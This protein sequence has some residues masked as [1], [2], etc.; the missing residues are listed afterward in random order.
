[1]KKILFAIISLMLSFSGV[2]AY[3]PPTMGWS[4]WNTYGFQISEQLIMSQTSAMVDKGLKDVGYKYINIDDGFFGGRDADGNLLIHPTRFPNGMKKVVDFIHGKGLKAGIYSDAGRN[5]CASFWGGDKIGE[6]VGLYG[7]DQ[8]DIDLYFKEL[9]F[10]FIKVDFCGGAPEHNVDKLDLPE[11]E[12]YRAIHEA[13]VNTGRTDVRLNVCRWAFPGTWVHEVATSWRV[14]EDI[15]LGWNSVKGIIGQTLYLSAFATEGKFND[16]DMLEVGRGLTA[17]EDKTHFGMWCMLSS[18]LLIGC[19]M[20]KLGG[21]ALQ[22]LKNEE[23]I[24]LNQ[25]PLALQAYVVKRENG[26]YVLV[27]DV[28]ELNGS[29]RAVAFYNP[30]D[31]EL[32]MDV[33]FID[34]DLGGSVKV[35]D[36]FEKEDIG[37]FEGGYDVKVPAH[38]TRI[39]KLEAEKRYE[40]RV[41]EAE[42]AW[43]DAYQELVNNQTAE[44]GI[45]EETD[46]CS[47]GA[48]A[49]WLGRSK[50]NSLEWRNVYSK[51]GGEYNI[52]IVYITGETRKVNVVVNGE[53][54]Q[55]LSLNSGGWNSPKTT[56]LTVNLQKGFNSIK[57]Y[58][59]SA[60]MP[61]IDCMVLDKVGVFDVY[62]ERIDVLCN[63]VRKLCKSN[64]IPQ[65]MK[66]SLQEAVEDAKNVE[67]TKDA[68]N[69]AISQLDKMYGDACETESVYSKY[70]AIMEVVKSNA[71]VT[72]ACDAL[73][74]C[75]ME[76][77]A[78]EKDMEASETKNEA[79]RV[80]NSFTVAV[81]GYLKS[82]EMQPQEGKNWDMTLLISN[83]SF[84]TDTKGWV[85]APVFGHSVAEHYNK[86]FNTYQT[87]TGLKN[88]L[89]TVQ[90]NAL[91]RIGENDG[92]R[93]YNAGTE[94]I[95]AKFFANDKNKPIVS[96]YTYPYEGETDCFGDLDLKNGYI[97]SMYAASIVFAKGLY[98]NSMDV[99]VADGKLKIGIN[100]TGHSYDS[101]C[102]FDNFKIVY[103]GDYSTSVSEVLQDNDSPVD[104]YG[105]NGML[106]HRSVDPNAVKYLPKGMYLIGG[107]IIVIR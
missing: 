42:T 91:Y 9:S 32:S 76:L 66:A 39:Y 27:K 8:D 70:L 94:S 22:L 54:L 47:G 77:S 40:R 50:K 35:R 95:A 52:D 90:V 93:S 15:Y 102:C 86:D 28:E 3:D 79:N 64:S 34:L 30:T 53:E 100:N 62:Q 51:D 36:L 85:G 106:L 41:Y 49:G 1:M 20:T 48:K 84:D 68:Y 18:P 56:T 98:L 38:G 24:A 97:N 58:N 16:M 31:A 6:G 45:Y 103:H 10:D 60:W 74:A 83:P 96:L 72:V 33:D 23:L 82:K 37:V 19:D 75:L 12:R 21:D 55:T 71:E 59:S 57:L 13:I 44:T 105:I 107:R 7:H 63:K 99:E 46:Y 88:G 73:S 67:S 4:S 104:I 61:D 14:S 69:S 26:A 11:E 78:F 92:G 101:W 81:K 80:L 2:H 29:K 87:L 89:Y 43:L 65:G 25:D 17:E 5:T